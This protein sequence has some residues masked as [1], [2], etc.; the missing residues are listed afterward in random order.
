MLKFL[1][2]GLAFRGSSALV[3]SPQ[4]GNFL[5]ISELLAEYNTF[6][7]KHIQKRVNKGKGH[8]S[9]FS[10]TVCEEYIDVR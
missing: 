6:L 5:G 4:N 7:A 8:F 3:G 2:R 1:S 10:S 9:C